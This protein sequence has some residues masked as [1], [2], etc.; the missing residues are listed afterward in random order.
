MKLI[1]KSNEK[2]T[3][4]EN[5]QSTCN[6][7]NISKNK[8]RQLYLKIV[9]LDT[10]PPPFSDPSPPP[11]NPHAKMQTKKHTYTVRWSKTLLLDI[12]DHNLL[13][14][15]YFSSWYPVKKGSI[16]ASQCVM[17]NVYWNFPPISL[18]R[19]R[20]PPWHMSQFPRQG[21]VFQ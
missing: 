19:Y 4:E 16:S 18:Y 14:F 9:L 13:K 1:L 21:K 20:L 5:S 8:H 15:N 10:P 11:K 17:W 12:D 6:K 7:E 3:P 2:F